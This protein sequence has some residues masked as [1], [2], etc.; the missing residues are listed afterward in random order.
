MSFHLVVTSPIGELERGRIIT[1]P[2]VIERLLADHHDKVVRV[3][4]PAPVSNKE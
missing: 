1:D 4:A 3:A 2:Q